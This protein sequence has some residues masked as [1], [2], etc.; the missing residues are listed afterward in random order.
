MKHCRVTDLRAARLDMQNT[1]WTQQGLIIY[2]SSGQYFSYFCFILPK[3]TQLCLWNDGD[4]D[5]SVSALSP[6]RI[7]WASWAVFR[8]ISD[9][10]GPDIHGLQ[11][12]NPNVFADPLTLH[13]NKYWM[14]CY[15]IWCYYCAQ[16]FP[17]GWITM[18]RPWLFI[19]LHQQ[20]NMLMST[21]TEL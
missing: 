13:L 6:V 9:G 18:L 10:C 3:L 16:L 12:I 2:I 11:R 17:T 7:V 4:I 5:Q 21:R 14:D 1:G 8:Y 20:W 19:Q 15:S